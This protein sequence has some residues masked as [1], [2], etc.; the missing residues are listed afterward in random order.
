MH[1]YN[2]LTVG[3]FS[4]KL[5]HIYMDTGHTNMFWGLAFLPSKGKGRKG[6]REEGGEGGRGRGRKGEREREEGGEGEGGRGR[7]RK[8]EGGRN[9]GRE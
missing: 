8:G 4:R 3:Q 9:G 7:G 2:I 1:F 6:E 5:S